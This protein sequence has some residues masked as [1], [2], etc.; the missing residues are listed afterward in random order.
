MNILPYTEEHHRFRKK[1]RTFIEKEIIPN[2]NQW[3]ADRLVPKSAWQ[4]MGREGFLC[5]SIPEKYGGHGYDLLYAVIIAEEL[6]RSNHYGLYAV[7]H[8]DVAAPYI[9]T[10]GSEYLRNKYLPG[11]CSGDII[12]AIA[13]TEPNAGSDLAA[14]KTTAVEDGDE[15][16]LNGSKI[17][18]S[19]GINCG[20]AVVAAKN[21]SDKNPYESI[22]LYV[23]ESDLPGFIRGKKL[24]K[25]GFHSQDT[26]ELFFSDCRIPKSNLLGQKGKGFL[27]LMEKL[28]LERLICSVQT[29]AAAE[30]SMEQILKHRKTVS[31]S[32]KPVPNTQVSQFAMVEMATEIKLG[33]T[34]LET[35]IVDH[36][37][38]KNV[39]KE[40]SMAKYWN[41]EL[42]RRV[43][44][45]CIDLYG[46]HGALESCPV[47]RTYRDTRIL[48]IAGGTTEIMKSIIAK[49]MGI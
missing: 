28:Q 16:V 31:S 23:V 24:E 4:K 8:S 1:A 21:F 48:S 38:G 19:N 10:F 33:R 30:F 18:I 5:T 40:T 37:D 14:M 2:V 22:S 42:A 35:L 3:E 20:V 13:M 17:F 9:Y 49:Q 32:D 46:M 27:M 12:T 26:I 39:L 11:C 15:I 7:L 43:A 47:V 41:S 29:I 34:M 25:M 6:A 44:E 45:R 36:M